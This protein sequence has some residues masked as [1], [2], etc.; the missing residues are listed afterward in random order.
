MLKRE[1]NVEKWVRNYLILHKNRKSNI[2]EKV[3]NKKYTKE[4]I[5]NDIKEVMEELKPIQIKYDYS[6][7]PKKQ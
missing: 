7:L 1:N 4:E 6:K 3:T 5:A 2:M